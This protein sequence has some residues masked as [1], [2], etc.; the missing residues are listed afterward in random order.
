[1]ADTPQRGWPWLNIFEPVPSLSGFR[2]VIGSMGMVSSPHH[3]ASSIGVEMLGR[4]GSAVDAAVATSAALMAL[5][6]M[7]CG[8]GGD[9]FWIIAEPD[10]S[11]SVLDATGPAARSASI[12]H[13]RDRGLSE[14]PK[15][16][17][18]AVTVPGAVDGWMKAH[19]RFGRLPIEDLLE[20]AARLAAGGVIVGR[21]CRSS[22]L[23]CEQELREKEAL[24]LFV[25]DD[26]VP[27]LYGRIN[28][29][30][31]AT[32]LRDL[33]RTKGRSIYEGPLAREIVRVCAQWSGF[34]GKDDLGDYEARWVQPVSGAFRTLQLFTAPPPSQGF[35]LL[36]AL[37]AVQ[38][39]A[40]RRLDVFS[41]QSS[42]LLIEAAGAALEIRDRINAD[43]ADQ[44]IG[45][46]IDEA[47]AFKD[48]FDP[49]RHQARMKGQHG[50]R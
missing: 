33:A 36:A 17:G 35:C 46:A 3:L 22:F 10:S 47:R 45:Q 40:P 24:G 50:G 15:R 13:F 30:N 5:C 26:A 38:L 42:H 32:S 49:T 19:A 28:Q 9:A 31:L 48:E 20:P 18:E 12:E 39:A 11:V 7:Q 34:L 1:M 27:D 4:G 44:R 29:P 37:Q 6:P 43:G 21:H 16:G 8:P 2:P 23:T 14:V 41:P 25:A